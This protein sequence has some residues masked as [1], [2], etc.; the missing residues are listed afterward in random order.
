M[1]GCPECR[2]PGETVDAHVEGYGHFSSAV[3]KDCSRCQ[4]L[5]AEPREFVGFNDE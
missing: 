1:A 2:R 5:W 4:V 3:V